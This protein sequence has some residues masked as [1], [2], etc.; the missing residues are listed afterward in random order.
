[1]HTLV[2]VMD[3]ICHDN[4]VLI[5][6]TISVY[7]LGT[8]ANREVERLLH[9]VCNAKTVVMTEHVAAIIDCNPRKYAEQD[10]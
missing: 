10:F 4:Y 6:N 9:A 8:Y 1:M 3:H 5:G 2:E 7:L